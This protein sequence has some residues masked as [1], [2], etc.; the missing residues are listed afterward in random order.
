MSRAFFLKGRSAAGFFLATISFLAGCQ[1]GSILT[2]ASP[3]IVAIPDLNTNLAQAASTGRPTIILI[4]DSGKSPADDRAHRLFDTMTDTGQ[5]QN[6]LPILLD[7][8]ASR[9]RATAA[10]FHAAMTPILLGLTPKGLIVTRDE[11]QITKE[12]IL[13]RIAEVAQRGP[14]LDTKYATLLAATQNDGNHPAAELD[15]GDFLLSISNAREA[16]PHLE[17]AAQDNSAATTL[18]VHAWIDLV[19]AHLWIAEIEK[20]RHEAENLLATLGTTS[21]EA[22]AGGKYA[23]GLE[24]IAAKHPK[25]ALQNLQDAVAAAPNSEYGKQAAETLATLPAH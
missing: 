21:P 8:G 10:R 3:R 4:V 16:I 7:L 18:R 9:N 11:R 6:A 22:L 23:L 2:T 5:L 15:L 13:Q 1:S 17:K 24:E 14:G 25:P 20:A 19:R 12:L